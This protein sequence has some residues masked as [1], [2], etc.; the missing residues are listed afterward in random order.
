MKK[1]RR[2]FLSDS[3]KIITGLGAAAIIPGKTFS[4]LTG[5]SPNEKVVVGLI[6]WNGIITTD[7][8]Q[9]WNRRMTI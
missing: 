7:A 3:G 4:I 1:N 6:G 8:S 5:G 2:D 9:M